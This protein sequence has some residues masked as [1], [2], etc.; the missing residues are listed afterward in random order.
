MRF[1]LGFIGAVFAGVL[2]IS[3]IS[4]VATYVSN[5]PAPLASEEFH[6]PPRPLHLA[7]DGPFGRFDKRAA[8]ARLPGLFGGLL[9]LPQPQ[10]WSRSA[11]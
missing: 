1:I 9:G 6:K 5:P 10:A 11:T 7:S 8:A 4:G 3:L 2:L